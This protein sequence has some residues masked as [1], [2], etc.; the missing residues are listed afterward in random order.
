GRER[1]RLAVDVLAITGWLLLGLV[2]AP[3]L[4]L[5]LSTVAAIVAYG[6]L[7]LAVFVYVLRFGRWQTAFLQTASWPITWSLMALFFAFCAYRL[8]LY[9]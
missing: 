2:V 6:V 4:G 3:I 9:Q 5:G 8:I 1:T 7:L